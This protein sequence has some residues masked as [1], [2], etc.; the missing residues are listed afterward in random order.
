MTSRLTQETSNLDQSFSYVGLDIEVRSFVKQRTHAIK[1][2]MRRTA[3]DIIDI[4][5][6]LIEIKD[7]LGHGKQGYFIFNKPMIC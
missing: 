4:G 6:K 2:L 1:S 7:I 5:L 3:Q